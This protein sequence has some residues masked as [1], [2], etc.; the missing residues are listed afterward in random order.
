MAFE[1]ITTNPNATYEVQ[2]TDVVTLTAGT[3][4]SVEGDGFDATAGGAGFE[5]LD[6]TLRIFGSVYSSGRAVDFWGSLGGV[7]VYRNNDIFIGTTGV[8]SG[9]SYGILT[10][11]GSNNSI[12]NMG[13]IVADIGIETYGGL[14]YLIQNS[15]SISGLQGNAIYIRSEIDTLGGTGTTVLNSAGGTITGM[16]AGGAGVSLINLSGGSV[17]RNWGEIHSVL[18]NAVNLAGVTL[19]QGLIS[20]YN[21]GTMSGGLGSYVGSGNAD[22]LFNRGVMSGDVVMGDGADVFNNRDGDVDGNWYG[23]DGT[24]LYSAYDDSSVT[25]VIDGGS[26]ND[27][28]LAGNNAD[29]ISG[30]TGSDSIN[31]GGGDDIIFGNND[32]DTIFAGDGQDVVYGGSGN[33]R[34]WGGAGDDTLEGSTGY[35][36]IRGGDGDDNITGGTNGDTIYGGNG[37]DTFIFTSVTDS[38]TLTVD[39]DRIMDFQTGVDEFDLSGIDADAIAAGDQAFSFL[40]AGAFTNVAGQL[41]YVVAGSGTGVLSGD[42]NGDGIADFVVFVSNGAALTANDFIL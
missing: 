22:Y 20:V 3:I 19:G 42:T 38:P 31:S 26:G 36:V 32:H 10:E 14:N 17:V 28:L 18:D 4:Y 40:G 16:G 15:G 24:D 8:L 27:T 6:V 23:G 30:G 35:D 1:V 25:G 13:T 29:S 37:A 2:D 39:R 9:Q 33:D 12:V 5:L 34:M 21:H 7:D 41:R 11:G